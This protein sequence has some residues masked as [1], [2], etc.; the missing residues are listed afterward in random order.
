MTIFDNAISGYFSSIVKS[1]LNS[2]TKPTST[3]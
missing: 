1:P 2:F 3:E